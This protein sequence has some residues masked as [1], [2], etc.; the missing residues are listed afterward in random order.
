MRRE[1]AIEI[2]NNTILDMNRK[3]A[4]EQNIPSQQ[5]DMTLDQMKPQLIRL[6]W[7]LQEKRP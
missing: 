3:M 2:M 7:A 1:D 4:E 5:I 6:S